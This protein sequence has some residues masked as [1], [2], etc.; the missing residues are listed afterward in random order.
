MHE[1]ARRF[2]VPE[3][4]G[5]SG[6]IQGEIE[7]E[8]ERDIW[9]RSRVIDGGGRLMVRGGHEWMS[10]EGRA[11]ERGGAHVCYMSGVWGVVGLREAGV[12]KG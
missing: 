2:P 4:H 1:I 7:G 12:S 3:M 11:V 10:G 9:G 5:R 8:A 6:E